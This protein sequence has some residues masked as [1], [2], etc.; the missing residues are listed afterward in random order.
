MFSCPFNVC[1]GNSQPSP[2]HANNTAIHH[3]RQQTI[4]AF[5]TPLSGV[6]C[7]FML[8]LPSKKKTTTTPMHSV[9]QDCVY[10][11]RVHL[12][13]FVLAGRRGLLCLRAAFARPSQGVFKSREQGGH[14]VGSDVVFLWAANRSAMGTIRGM[15]IVG[16]GFLWGSDS[17]KPG[18]AV[19]SVP[20]SAHGV[21]SMVC[22]SHGSEILARS[23]W[24]QTYSG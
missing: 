20:R 22:Q 9:H 16:D 13:V 19:A 24:P 17:L 8:G 14:T 7:A 15:L 2:R 12:C 11:V 21:P 3:Q 5:L 18:A 1:Q 10:C 6:S 23:L 4:S